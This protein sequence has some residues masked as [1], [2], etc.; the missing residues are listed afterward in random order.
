MVMMRKIVLLICLC[1]FLCCDDDTVNIPIVAACGVDNPIEDLP[2]LRSLADEINQNESD[3]APFFFI[4]M[5]EY[6]G[7]TIFISNNCCPICSTIVPVYNCEGEFLSFLNDKIKLTDT[8]NLGVI[9][10]RDD[11]SCQ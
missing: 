3:V 8:R 5:A 7:E 4:E 10:K 1:S 6:E 9:F 11:F 2:W